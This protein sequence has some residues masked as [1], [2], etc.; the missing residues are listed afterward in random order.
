MEIVLA[1]GSPRRV[2]LLTERG[3][4][5]TVDPA[6]VDET[7]LHGESPV[8]LALRLARAKHVTVA[9]RHTGRTVVAADTVVDLD[10]VP[11]G[12]PSS[13]DDARRM[14]SALSGRPHLVHTAVAVGPAGSVID[15]VE[16]TT[17]TF[18]ALSQDRLEWY[19]LSGEWQGKA[20]GYAVQGLGMALVASVRGSLSNVVG[21]PV[22]ETLALLR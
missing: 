5:C 9:V 7:P 21:L 3:I 19:L 16:T 11:L 20:G 12:Q 2:Q 13:A 4:R 18:R 8:D 6:D 14:L 10:G 15:H 22:V 17:V 1:S